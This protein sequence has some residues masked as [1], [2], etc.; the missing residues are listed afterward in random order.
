MI[1]LLQ[2]VVFS[3]FQ[4]IYGALPFHFDLS[5]WRR[6]H[7]SSDCTTVHCCISGFIEG[8]PDWLF[9]PECQTRLKQNAW[10]RGQAAPIMTVNSISL[11]GAADRLYCVR[12]DRLLDTKLVVW[13]CGNT[14]W[15]CLSATRCSS[16]PLGHNVDPLFLKINARL[17]S[18][19][20]SLIWF[21]NKKPPY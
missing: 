13:D 11:I 15:I 3:V 6:I 10:T 20:N 18:W 7:S 2:S 14:L 8:L 12:I 5:C 17:M 19:I 9:V 1:L 21:T 16:T 4:T